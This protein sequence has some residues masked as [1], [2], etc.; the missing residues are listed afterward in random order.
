MT[1][2][3]SLRCTQPFIPSFKWE[4]AY[5]IDLDQDHLKITRYEYLRSSINASKPPTLEGI[6]EKGDA[7]QFESVTDVREVEG[8][9]VLGAL[10]GSVILPMP[11]VTDVN[12]ADWGKSELNAQGMAAAGLASKLIGQPGE[13]PDERE[14]RLQAFEDLRNQ[15][16]GEEGHGPKQDCCRRLIVLI[17]GSM[18]ARQCRE[19]A[20][21]PTIQ[22]ALSV[23][24]FQKDK[25]S[26]R[27]HVE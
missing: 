3:F 13:T 21:E 7:A 9:T 23:L 25:P 22:A 11:K 20:R 2:P 16:G 24:D 5:D 19:T 10:K 14:R 27:F 15:R 8:G 1:V 17:R 4:I 12:A 26:T 18:R 6:N